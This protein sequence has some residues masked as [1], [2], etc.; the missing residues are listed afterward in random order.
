MN[1]EMDEK[2]KN[3]NNTGIYV[4]GNVAENKYGLIFFGKRRYM[5][6]KQWKNKMDLDVERRV[7]MAYV[8]KGI[9]IWACNEEN[10]QRPRYVKVHSMLRK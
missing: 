5:S 2:W 9:V 6:V 10:K 7:W 8:K 1:E 3:N 4:Y